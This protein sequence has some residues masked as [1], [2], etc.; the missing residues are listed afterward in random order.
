MHQLTAQFKKYNVNIAI[1]ADPKVW[2]D[3]FGN[4]C[5][6]LSTFP[7]HWVAGDNS[8]SFSNFKAFGGWTTPTVK[9]YQYGATVCNSNVDLTYRA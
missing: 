7:L 3:Q 1:A 5:T 4:V 9:L 6:D 2:N 8:A